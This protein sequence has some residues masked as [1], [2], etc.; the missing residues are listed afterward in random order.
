MF[1][2]EKRL[3]SP[4]EYLAQERLAD[5][6]SEFYRGEMFAKSGAS[7]CHNLIATNVLGELRGALKGRP[8]TAYN[9]DLRIRGASSGL[10]T[11]PDAGVVCG[12]FEYDDVQR[13]TAL[14]GYPKKGT[15]SRM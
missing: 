7:R 4:Q 5:F 3:L 12:D 9:C 2:G 13:D 8:C 1:T 10:Y 15:G 6:R 14:R 11:Y